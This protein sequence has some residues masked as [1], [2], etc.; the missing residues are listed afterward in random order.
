MSGGAYEYVMGYYEKAY[1][2][3]DV[4]GLKQEWKEQWFD[5][6]K[7]E[8]IEEDALAKFCKYGKKLE[9]SGGIQGYKYVGISYW[10]QDNDGADAYQM[11]FNINYA[12]KETLF[13]IIVSN[14]G[15]EYFSGDGSFQTDP[16]AQ[17][18]IWSEY[19]WQDYEGCYFDF[20]LKEYV[21]PNESN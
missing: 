4:A 1:E 10:G 13:D 2:Y 19:L 8:N 14:H 9:E 3:I 21:Y 20:N 18:A 17:F 16:L 12:G 6:K 5:E 15:V 11:I 7:L